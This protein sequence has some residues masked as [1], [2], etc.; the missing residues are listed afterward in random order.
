MVRLKV[1]TPQFYV[2]ETMFQFQYG[3]IKR[4]KTKSLSEILLQFQFQYG[5]IKSGSDFVSSRSTPV[6]IPIWYD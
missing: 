5:T 6:S 4:K 3:T 1:K 2:Q